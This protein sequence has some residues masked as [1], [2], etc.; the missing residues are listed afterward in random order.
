MKKLVSVKTCLLGCV[1]LSLVAV[2]AAP[3][4]AKEPAREFLQG[5]RERGYYDMAI[6]Y[7]ESMKTSRLAPVEMKE[8]LLYEL[9]ATL[10]EASRAQRDLATREKQLDEARDALRRFIGMHPDHQLASAAN[11]QL[12]NL[13][14]ERA[15]IKVDVSKKPGE[16]KAAL[17][18]EATTLYEDAYKV[19]ERAQVDLKEKLQ[20]YRV[21]PETEK[22]K[23]AIRDQLREDYLHSLLLGAAIKEESADTAGKGSD[24][25]NALLTEAA[26]KYE[27]ITKDYRRWVGGQY[28]VM[29]RGRCNLKMGKYKDALSFF[30]DILDQPDDEDAFRPLKT[31]T[32]LL[33]LDCWENSDPPLYAVAVQKLEPWVA[34]VRPV[35][36]ETDEWL[37]LRLGL[38]RVQ[39]ELAQQ[40]KAKD[41]RDAQAKRLTTDARKNAQVITRVK[42]VSS[43][44]KKRA[45]DLLA[46]IGVDVSD[47]TEGAD[48]KTFAEAMQAGRS[49]LDAMQ[50]AGIVLKEVPKRIAKEKDEAV[51]A[52]LQKQLKD[53]GTAATTAAADAKR[54][55]RMALGLVDRDTDVRDVNVVRYF[56]CFL[57][58]SAKEYYDAG[59]VGEFVA[60]RYPDSAGARPS[61]KIAM[62][63]YLKLYTDSESEDKDFEKNHIVGIANYIT[64]RWSDEPEAVDALNTLIPFMIQAGDLAMAEKYLN[65]IPEDS[66]KRGDA[67][68]KTGQAMWSAYLKGMHEIRKWEAGDEPM[69]EGTDVQ[70]KKATL[71]QLKGRAQT[72]LAAGVAR[73]QQAGG[74]TEPVVTAALSLA[75]IYVDTEQVTKAVALLEDKTIGPLTLVE[76]GHAATTRENFNAEVYKTA[77]RAY[78]SSLAGAADS[79]AVI[80]KATGVMDAMKA[81]IEQDKLI[82][83]YVGLARDLEEQIKLASPEAK[84]PLSKGFETFL[85]RLRTGS[86]ELS[87]LNWVAATFYSLGKGFDTGTQLP[88]EAKVYYQEA[89]DTYEEILKKVKFD[90]PDMQTQIRLRL[91]RTK[92]KLGKFVDARNFYVQILT[93]KNMTLDVQVEA[94]LLYQE[95]AAF[96]GKEALYLKALAGAEPNPQTGKNIIWGWGRLFQITAKYPEYRNVFHE[97]RYNLAV[98]R[99]NMSSA[100]KSTDEKTELLNKAKRAILQTQQLY[101]KGAEWEAWRPRYDEL[102]KKVQRALR[103]KAVGLPKDRAPEPEEVVTE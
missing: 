99:L 83:M 51:K 23:L 36:K 79:D 44:L 16:D 5:L 37:E 61:A 96:P 25:Y 56:L 38:A 41:P 52:Q 45:T 50:T 13:L 28:A 9:G 69:P 90:K 46:K 84:K 3:A 66:A 22:E 20:K 75:Q 30:E 64:Q 68:I 47:P 4:Q 63:A 101:G 49:A 95:W 76:A 8:I 92:L 60:R 67:E 21:V 102:M 97:A 88:A 103:E 39:A 87:V 10:I 57:H 42:G 78:I 15:R 86:T 80:K 14:V 59:L 94:A 62:A 43:D 26:E 53:A 70:E 1:V 65:D 100:A 74:V 18:S 31:K 71:D 7:L 17:L 58:Y 54:Y 73:M 81:A 48:P 29:Y 12:G 35:E 2:V 55:Y 85:K 11:N 82:D 19:F 33:A 89:A 32:L 91:A 34:K 72:I 27:N 40:L 93:E 24:Q 77:L 98:C 6:E